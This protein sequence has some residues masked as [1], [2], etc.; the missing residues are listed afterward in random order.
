M[1]L[2]RTKNIML[3]LQELISY[4]YDLN[5]FLFWLKSKETSILLKQKIYI[6]I[7]RNSKKEIYISTWHLVWFIWIIYNIYVIFIFIFPTITDLDLYLYE[8][9]DFFFCGWIPIQYL[10]YYIFAWDQRTISSLT[11]FPLNFLSKNEY[12]NLYIRL[13]H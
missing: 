6:L 11:Q 5:S 4:P 8:K 1:L 10:L 9:L 2:I 7:N 12:L 3:N 13:H